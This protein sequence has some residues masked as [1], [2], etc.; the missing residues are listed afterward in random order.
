ME[1]LSGLLSRLTPEQRAAL[2]ALASSPEA[3]RLGERAGN[4]ELERAVRSG[5]PAALRSMAERLLSTRVGN[6]L[7]E[8]LS[9]P[10]GGHG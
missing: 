8:K 5:D 4:G 10:K 6:A 9:G 1:D 7:A 2:N 3:R